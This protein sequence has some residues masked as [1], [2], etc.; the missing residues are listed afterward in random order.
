MKIQFWK[1]YISFLIIL[2]CINNNIS[3]AQKINKVDSLLELLNN[4]NISENKNDTGLIMLNIDIGIELKKSD[5][6][7]ALKFFNQALILSKDQKNNRLTARSYGYIGLAYLEKSEYDISL[8]YF[9]K[10]LKIREQ[11]DDKNGISLSYSNIGLAYWYKEDR[12]NAQKYYNKSAEIA[13]KLKDNDQLSDCYSNLG[14]IYWEAENYENAILYHNKSIEID[15]IRK[16]TVQ[17]AEGLLNIGNIYLMKGNYDL[18]L[19]NFQKSA[20]IYEKLYPRSS[21]ISVKQGLSYC[22]NNIGNVHMK[23]SSYPTAA[24][25]YKK[26]LEIKKEYGDVNGMAGCYTNLGGIDWSREDYTAAIKSFEN[27]LELYKST[28]NIQG[29]SRIYGN[30]GVIY[31]LI[32][33]Y[34]IAIKYY[35]DALKIKEEINDKNGTAIVLVNIAL[36]NITYADST[37]KTRDEAIKY[38]MKAIEYATKALKIGEETE[39]MPRISASAAVLKE[40]Y[41]FLGDYKNAIKYADLYI[42]ARDSMFGAE[43]LQAIQEAESK[44][45]AE[46]KQLEIEKME[47]QK[48]LTTQIIKTQRA[49]NKKQKIIIIAVIV[50]LILVIGFLIITIRMF[51]QKR[52]ANII[53]EQQK[54][55]ILAQRDEIEA[56]RDLAATQRDLI[57]D[58]NKDITDSIEYAYM[59]QSAI[60]PAPED[61]KLI[62][63]DYFIFYKPRDIVSGDFYWINKQGS[64]IIIIAADC[65]GHGVPGAFMS[66]LGVAF[67]NEIVNKENITNPARILDRLRENIILALKQRGDRTAPSD[68][69]DVAAITIDPRDNKLEFAGAN[70][71]LYLIQNA[72]LVETK[73]DKMPVSIHSKM[74]PFTSHEFKIQEGDKIYI[75]SD[76]YADQFGGEK[77]KKLKYGPFKDMLLSFG[78]MSMEEQKLTIER[79]YHIW[80]GDFSQI[81]DVLVM[82]IKI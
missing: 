67:L 20:K 80:K 78:D 4:K 46:K 13:L 1:S 60:F 76:G 75:F 71:P 23:Q 58:Q 8:K 69:M 16:D 5:P 77:G 64:K 57:A 56:Q 30:L 15:S 24:E 74:Y 47:K 40:A 32:G 63:K 73:G 21:D 52:L 68:G 10:S 53:L 37:A 79:N 54:E 65:T 50:G 44:Y 26:S 34:D 31:K 29:M 22:Y 25:Y 19:N 14:S 41:R 43:K 59:I 39:T 81:D 82:G 48:L 33:N 2:L 12:E 55:E 7:S 61:I 70:N 49:E 62:L 35:E 6:D 38:Y 36:L 28:N 27:A 66:M 42:F 17:I 72:Q 9:N 11:I 51:R 18:A 45:Q 3:N